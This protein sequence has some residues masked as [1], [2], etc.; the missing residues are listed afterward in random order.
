MSC[1][2]PEAKGQF[3]KFHEEPGETNND[4]RDKLHELHFCIGKSV[5]LH[6][7]VERKGFNHRRYRFKY[8]PYEYK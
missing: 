4:F 7:K 3:H 6:Q 1:G 5:S 2:N 8:R